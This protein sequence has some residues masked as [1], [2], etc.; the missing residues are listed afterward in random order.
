MHLEHAT[1]DMRKMNNTPLRRFISW[2]MLFIIGNLQ[3]LISTGSVALDA[4][5][6]GGIRTGLIT[7]IYGESGS[8]KSQLCFTIAVNCAKNGGKVL[9]VDTSGTF[10]AERIKEIG[11]TSA[12]LEKIVYLRALGSKDQAS[13]VNRIPEIEPQLVIID[14]LTSLFS[15]EYSGAS[16]HLAVMKHLHDLAITA[17]ASRCAIMV[18]NM[19][20]NVPGE[21]KDKADGSSDQTFHRSEQKEY[22]GSSV[23][24]YSHIKLKLEIVDPQRSIFRAMLIQPSKNEIALFRIASGGIFDP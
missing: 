15:V 3:N 22:L 1:L 9:F 11:G 6:G 23:S 19:V 4:L 24:I 20:R 13:V 14:D 7:D 12:L 5:L 8:G 17:I 16:R 18:T 2:Q 10:R 21:I